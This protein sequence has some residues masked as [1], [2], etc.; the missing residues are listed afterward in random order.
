MN[1]EQ[2]RFNMVEQQIRTWNVLDTKV[3]GL[4]M[5]IKREDFV[6]AE[7]RNIAL[8]DSEIPLPGGQ[9][10]LCPRLE[11]RLVQELCL[12][13]KDKV[14][15][16]GTGS[17]YL[18]ALLAKLTDFVYTVELNTINKQ[19]ALDNLTKCGIKNVSVLGVD[20]IHGLAN[21]A[22][23]D[24]I[25]IGGSIETIPEDL[26]QQLK[27]GGLL[28]AICGREPIMQAVLI[29]KI[30]ENQYKET[31]LFETWVEPLLNHTAPQFKF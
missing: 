9:K 23:F 30:A 26:K 6:S 11:A 25:C 13:K 12:D 14:L 3:L 5:K 16:I 22:P 2:A 4:L 7:Y 18:T 24:K 15:E 10:M 28:I 21:K 17:G 1:F 27:I 20:G 19:F 29:K 31:K 8:A